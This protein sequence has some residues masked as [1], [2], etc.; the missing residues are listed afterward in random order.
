M[1][2]LRVGFLLDSLSPNFYSRDLIDFVYK[3]E[4]FET[5]VLITGYKGNVS[6]S[7]KIKKSLIKFFKNPITTFDSILKSL[8]YRFIYLIEIRSVKKLYPNYASNK[9]L[10]NQR[11]FQIINV[12]G[13][14][15]KSEL[16]LEFNEEEL[17]KI[18]ESKLDCII[19]C[20]SGILRGGILDI[21]RFGVISFHHGDNRVNRGGPSG[22]WEVFLQEPSSGFIIQ[23]LNQELDGGQVLFR[24]NLMT[25]N[26]WLKNNANLLEK[27]N[28]FLKKLILDLAKSKNLPNFEGVTLHGNKLYKIRSSFE[29]LRYIYKI[30]LPKFLNTLVAFFYSPLI[31]RWSVAFSYHNNFS[32]SLWR[33]KEIKNPKGRFL[34][35]PFIIEH[36][37]LN[38]IFVE[39]FLY[40]E[41][42][43]RI[44]AIKI[45]G[46]SYDFLGVILEED[47][48]LSFPFIFKD[49]E[50]I[51]MIPE[52]CKNQDIRLYK[53]LDFPYS[54]KFEKQLM[55]D[56]DAADTMLLQK[57]D[58]WFMF[59][60]ICSSG[61]KDHQSELHI[62]YSKNL[63]TSS[64][65]AIGSGNPVIFDPLTGRNG[66]IFCHNEK[67]YRINQ[68]HD[69]DH[70]GKSFN[71]NEIVKIT[72][73]EFLEKKVSVVEPNF[74]PSIISTH[75]FSANNVLA[76]VDYARLERQKS[77][78]K[79]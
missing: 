10:D 62:F 4:S 52:S 16:F 7:E 53:C 30:I 40:N 76:A 58:T 13:S 15:S 44:S 51:Y 12:K 29:Y 69:Q 20:G 11:D 36:N 3:N 37:G 6:Q 8:L 24:G 49:G 43:G 32:K 22:F 56:V 5:P 68:V 64:W 59:T 27:S 73:D 34:A 47:F 21:T 28:I 79:K 61:I 67:T 70:Y 26:L 18:S 55:A 46:D 48:H 60:N 57:D 23:K 9:I 75:H 50:D 1:R 45:D 38:Y 66:G 77:V 71:V 65:N 72:Q 33:Y 25:S 54:W 19:R 31:I 78:L 41:N 39:D 74:K 63:K 14:W 42:K 2:K 35:D 17:K